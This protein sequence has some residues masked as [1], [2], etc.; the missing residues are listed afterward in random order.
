VQ[1][2]KYCEFQ[3]QKICK[4][5]VYVSKPVLNYATGLHARIKCDCAVQISGTLRYP[6]NPS[7]SE[8]ARYCNSRCVFLLPSEMCVDGSFKTNPRAPLCQPVS[9]SPFSHVPFANKRCALSH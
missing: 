4:N 1:N 7:V 5:H 3:N 8:F 6:A 9:Y 2:L